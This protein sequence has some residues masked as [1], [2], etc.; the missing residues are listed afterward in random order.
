MYITSLLANA[1]IGKSALLARGA[2][3]REAETFVQ[4]IIIESNALGNP[5]LSYAVYLNNTL[6]PGVLSLL[7]FILTA[8]SVTQ[9]IKYRTAA[10]WIDTAQNNIFVAVTGKLLPQTALFSLIA[11]LYNIF[12]YVAYKILPYLYKICRR[13]AVSIF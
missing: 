13:R 5:W 10:K 7:I 8:Y 6:F 3:D 9:E 1:A 4:P 2:T 12:L 11:I